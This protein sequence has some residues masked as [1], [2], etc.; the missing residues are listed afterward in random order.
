M[1]F[2]ESQRNPGIQGEIYSAQEWKYEAERIRD[3]AERYDLG[4]REA[5]FNEWFSGSVALNEKSKPCLYHVTS[6]GD[7]D[8]FDVN[9]MDLGIHAG[10]F[11]QVYHLGLMQLLM[12]AT[13]LRLIKIALKVT[14]PW[15]CKDLGVWTP[16]RVYTELQRTGVIDAAECQRMKAAHEERMEI[17]S[18]REE[19]AVCRNYLQ[20]LGFDGIAYVNT[21]EAPFSYHTSWVAFRPDQVWGLD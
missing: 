1:I 12:E 17:R 21:G 7:F 8:T 13:N 4:T 3:L 20:E 10:T 5:A 18:Y 11:D 15:Y 2:K 19:Q 9:Q 16:N 6:N 14:N